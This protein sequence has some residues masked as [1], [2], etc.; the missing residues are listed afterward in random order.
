MPAIRSSSSLSS[1]SRRSY[2][3]NSEPFNL[4]FYEFI[5]LLN[6]EDMY[7]ELMVSIFDRHDFILKSTFMLHITSLI[8][9]LQDEI[10][11]QQN[12]MRQLFDEMQ[13]GGLQL[14]LEREFE[15]KRG[16][17]RKRGERHFPRQDHFDVTHFRRPSTPHPQLRP[18]LSIPESSAE[19]SSNSEPRLITIKKPIS[20]FMKP[21]SILSTSSSYHTPLLGT[22]ENLI[23][24]LDD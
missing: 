10:D 21:I 22:R 12:L 2:R 3:Q 14:M 17:I 20:S 23:E 4:S 19:T 18:E 5:D 6:N 9:R 8:K 13:A 7:D 1:F 11:V 24:I 15:R 16:T